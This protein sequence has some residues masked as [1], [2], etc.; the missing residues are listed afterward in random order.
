[1]KHKLPTH[2][3]CTCCKV[4]P[5][6]RVTL[7]MLVSIAVHAV[8]LCEQP[9]GSDDVFPH[10]PRFAWLCNRVAVATLLYTYI[11]CLCTYICTILAVSLPR[12]FVTAFGWPTTEARVQKEQQFGVLERLWLPNW[13]PPQKIWSLSESLLII[14]RCPLQLA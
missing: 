5:L 11:C 9:S 10:H 14:S 1:M 2:Q 7:L 6:R 4:F 12:Y 3:V 8:P 13:F